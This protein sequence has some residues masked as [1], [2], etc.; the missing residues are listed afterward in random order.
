MHCSSSQSHCPL[1]SYLHQSSI[2]YSLPNGPFFLN[3][4]NHKRPFINKLILVATLQDFTKTTSSKTTPLLSTKTQNSSDGLIRLVE[5]NKGVTI[6]QD[7]EKSNLDGKIC[8]L[9]L[10]HKI[11]AL[12]IAQRNDILDVIKKDCRFET[13]ATFNNF[14]LELYMA[15]EVDFALKLF[16]ELSNFVLVPNCGTFSLLIRCYCKKNDPFEAHRVLNE[17][18][19]K[20]FQPNVAIFTDLINSF[21]KRG[22]MQKAFE[23]LEI[24]GSVRCEPTAHTYN[25]LLKG[26]CYVGRI[27]E[28]YKMLMN[29]KK[30][31]SIRPDIYT[32]TA[33]MNGFCK[34]GRS[35]EALEL[36]DDAVEMGLVP[37]VVTYNTLLN[38]YF[39]EGRPLEG[40]GLLNKMKTRN[41]AP[42]YISYSTLLHGLLKWSKIHSALS[43]YMEM[44]SVGFQV[45][46]RMMNTLLRG[47]CRRSRTERELLSNAYEVFD[48][49]K[50]RGYVMYPCAYELA[51][52]AFCIGKQID[53]ALAT[54][55]EMIK[56]GHSPRKMTVNNVIR[57]LCVEGNLVEALP[58]LVLMH[59]ENRMGIEFPFDILIDECNR[60]GI[61]MCSCTIYGAALKRGVVPQSKPRDCSAQLN[62]I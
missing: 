36:L 25:C 12:P 58:I 46:E 40:I 33:V 32:Y 61:Y 21:S 11:K 51:I 49:M 41:C 62:Q 3:T 44:V 50:S 55:C 16:S 24:M 56:S 9:H 31:T 29:I 35:D 28:A 23:V 38:G 54:L 13:I 18:V 26:L 1:T 34:V 8:E 37:N 22:R 43:I 60:Q 45:E 20:R 7:Y 42:D 17:M 53:K 27:E 19:E 15:D 47:L 57:P 6:E 39:K 4:N 59:E 5:E 2:T 30:S 10:L 14:F 52:E 48:R